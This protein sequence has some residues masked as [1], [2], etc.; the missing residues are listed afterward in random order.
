MLLEDDQPLAL[1]FPAVECDEEEESVKAHLQAL[2]HGS[3]TPSQAADDFNAWVVDKA[4]QRLHSFKTRTGQ[5][6][7]EG[8]PEEESRGIDDIRAVGPYPERLLNKLFEAI[9]KICS[10]FPPFH[11]GEDLIL[12]FLN[13]LRATPVQE[14]PHVTPTWR[15]ESSGPDAPGWE[16]MKLWPFEDAEGDL[17]NLTQSKFREEAEEVYSYKYSD[18]ETL[19][20]ELR[21]RWR[22][23]QCFCARLTVSGLADCTYICSLRRYPA[24][25]PPVP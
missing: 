18:I 20:S 24:L 25:D 6:R 14:V 13:A 11:A 12:D 4:E 8:T 19:S 2:L 22:N 3:T 21:I 17:A 23:F 7:Y 1:Q 5:A 10:S 15:L 9:A 16:V